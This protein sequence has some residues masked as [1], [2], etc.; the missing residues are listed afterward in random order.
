MK[1]EKE[2]KI[3]KVEKKETSNNLK[4][5]LPVL[6]VALVAL[7]AFISLALK[8]KNE[9]NEQVDTTPIVDTGDQNESNGLAVGGVYD[10]LSFILDNVFE[11]VNKDGIMNIKDALKLN[12]NILDDKDYKN[13]FAFQYGKE[14]EYVKYLDQEYTG[15]TGAYS[16]TDLDFNLLY[17]MIYGEQGTV[18][19]S[20]F[21]DVCYNKEVFGDNEDM[22]C[23]NDPSV[24]YYNSG[25]FTGY[26]ESD[27]YRF[28]ETSKT[29][30]DEDDTYTVFAKIYDSKG[31]CLQNNDENYCNNELVE[32]GTIM[33]VYEEVENNYVFHSIELLEK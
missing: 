33:I 22:K 32:I 19:S 4:I 25:V 23:L 8:D 9:E 13:E 26:S 3:E 2:E 24:K 21:S 5:I 7:A 14:F 10:N 6:C 20:I 30:D 27:E 28:E 31:N 16:I 1:K 15:E 17:E 18:D 12:G 11:H 29:H